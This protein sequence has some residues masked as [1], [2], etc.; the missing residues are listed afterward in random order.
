VND[1]YQDIVVEAPSS[2]SSRSLAIVGLIA[3]ALLL[4]LIGQRRRQRQHYKAFPRVGVDLG[5][6]DQR[7]RSAKKDFLRNASSLLDQGTALVRVMTTPAVSLINQVA[8]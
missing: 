3:T 8:S 6:F 2:S 7:L 1:H 4:A 5:F